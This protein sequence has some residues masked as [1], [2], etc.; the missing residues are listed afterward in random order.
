MFVQLLY[1]TIRMQT[2]ILFLSLLRI[3]LRQK[4]QHVRKILPALLLLISILGMLIHIGPN[5]PI[6]HVGK[7]A[8]ILQIPLIPL[9]FLIKQLIID[10]RLLLN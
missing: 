1:L 3:N 9:P 2:V 7:P 4:G 5:P 10:G 6:K 8:H